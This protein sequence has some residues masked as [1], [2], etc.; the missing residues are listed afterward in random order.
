MNQYFVHIY[1]VVRTKISIEA[2]S[3][4]E[5]MKLADGFLPRIE[6][7]NVNLDVE[8]H[9]VIHHTE[10]A[11]EVVGYLVDEVGDDEYH[12]SVSYDLNYEPVSS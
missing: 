5:A 11:E 9:G 3:Q 10:S 4:I 6:S 2:E 7:S 1:H 8:R 12:N